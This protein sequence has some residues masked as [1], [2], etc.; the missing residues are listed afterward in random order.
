M[1]RINNINNRDVEV[2]QKRKMGL[3]KENCCE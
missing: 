2:Q 1:I 3:Q